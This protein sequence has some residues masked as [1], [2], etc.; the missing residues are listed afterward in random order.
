MVACYFRTLLLL[1][2]ALT[3]T[4][5]LTPDLRAQISSLSDDILVANR[6]LDRQLLEGHRLLDADKVMQLFSTSSEVF[7]IAPDGELYEGRDKVRQS[8]VRFFA[9][10]QSIQGEINNI[11]YAPAGDGVIAVGHVTYHRVLKNGTR[12]QRFVVW[13]DYRK[14]ENGRWVYVFRH[15][16]WPLQGNPPLAPVQSGR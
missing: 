3:F 4:V 5:G 6:E 8:W 9:Q 1:S 13:T 11:S 16:H 14:K 2:C 12:D 10:L 7:F 15:A